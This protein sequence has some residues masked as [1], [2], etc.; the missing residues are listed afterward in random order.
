M[1][2]TPYT[3]QSD[4]YSLSLCLCIQTTSADVK[5]WSA[6]WA[7]FNRLEVIT[8]EKFKSIEEYGSPVREINAEITDISLTVEQIIILKLLK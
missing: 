1:I 6:K 8:D 2:S 5:N 4:G 3:T 7:T